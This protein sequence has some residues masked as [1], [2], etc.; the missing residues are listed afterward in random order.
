[1]AALLL[2]V[3]PANQTPGDILASAATKRRV[4]LAS[5]AGLLLVSLLLAIA[6]G[7]YSLSLPQLLAALFSPLLAGDASADSFAAAQ[8]VWNIRLPRVLLAAIAGAGLALAGCALQGLFRNPLA[9]P[10]LIGVASGAAL[11][12]AAAIVFAPFLVGPISRSLGLFILPVAAFAGSLLAASVIFKLAQHEG[13]TAVLMMLLAGIAINAICGAGI[14]LLVYVASDE[15]LRSITMW[16]LGSLAAA[17]WPVV[18]VTSCALAI[19]CVAVLR[20]RAA[21]DALCLG[22]DNAAQMGI[23]LQRTKRVVVLATTLMVAA[24][25]AFTGIIGFVGLV[26]PHMVRLLA[27]P[28]Q[29]LLM[30]AS[31]CLG[32]AIMVTADLLART[33]AAPAEIPIGVITALLG[34]PLFLGLLARQRQQFN[35]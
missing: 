16:T 14:G 22:E 21:L 32:A 35:P 5:L 31:A 33:L 9:D 3:S 17:S 30:P 27:G 1:M 11:F 4:V 6:I 24:C 29:R 23:D 20:Q 13:R 34:A 26:A 18:A 25:V 7:A 19:G 2:E 10:G 28:G 8:I 12:A 15:Q